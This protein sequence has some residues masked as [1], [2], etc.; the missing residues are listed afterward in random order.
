MFFQLLGMV[1]ISHCALLQVN[2]YIAILQPHG[3]DEHIQRAA[4][5]SK[6]VQE[7]AA[8]VENNLAKFEELHNS[9]F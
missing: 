7:A 3:S 5:H 4:K 1:V 9:I 8:L 6:T 2:S